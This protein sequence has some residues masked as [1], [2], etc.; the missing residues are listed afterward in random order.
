MPIPATCDLRRADWTLCG[1]GLPQDSA[2]AAVILAATGTGSLGADDTLI[3]APLAVRRRTVALGVDEA[4][5]RSELLRRHFGDV[6]GSSI[7]LPELALR[8]ARVA[9]AADLLPRWRT[10]GPL[11]LDLL[12]RDARLGSQRLWLHPREFALLWRLAE[13]QGHWVSQAA[14]RRELWG[15]SFRPETNSLAVHICRLR[16]RLRDGGVAGLI[17]TA[18]DGAYR[19]RA[20][21]AAFNFQ[22]GQLLLDDHVRLRDEASEQQRDA[23]HEAGIQNQ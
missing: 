17:E 16:T 4:A 2:D 11:T 3:G 6:L 22:P 9:R 1:L 20:A 8:A 23:D 18:R 10:A 13:V 14:L 19:L 15:Q 12:D 7:R 21:P 5:D